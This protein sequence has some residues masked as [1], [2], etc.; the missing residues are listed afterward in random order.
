M[1]KGEIVKFLRS[2][3][4]CVPVAL[5]KNEKENADNRKAG[6]LSLPL[7]GNRLVA[8]H[9]KA[10]HTGCLKYVHVLHCGLAGFHF[11]PSMTLISKLLYYQVNIM[12]LQ[13]NTLPS[14]H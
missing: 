1:M 3:L 2:P 11:P 9:I 13:P 6:S 8:T 10:V 14:S 4:G 7:A 12:G 5:E